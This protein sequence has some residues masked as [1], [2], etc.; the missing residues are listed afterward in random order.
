[1]RRVSFGRALSL[2][3]NLSSICPDSEGAIGSQYPPANSAGVIPR[4]SSSRASGLPRVSATICSRTRSSKGPGITRPSS[5]LASN[6]P[7]PRTTSSGRRENSLAN[8]RAPNT[9]TTDSATNR[10]ATN[11]S[12]SA[13]A[14]SNHCASSTAHRSGLLL[15]T[16]DSRLSI[17]SPTRK[18]LG[19][20]PGHKPNAT[21]SAPR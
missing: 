15:A 17:A 10:R 13:D 4:G 6:L 3:R 19:R 7:R 21:S 14:L 11:A 8:N 9:R 20:S 2:W 16:S 12:V 18:R 5:V 1:M